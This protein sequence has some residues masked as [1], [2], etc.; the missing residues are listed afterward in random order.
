MDKRDAPVS[1]A[2]L[3]DDLSELKKGVSFLH[4]FSFIISKNA[5]VN[6]SF[7]WIFFTCIEF[8]NVFFIW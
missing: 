7:F 1:I 3:W 6:S 4:N 5:L 8:P 2:K